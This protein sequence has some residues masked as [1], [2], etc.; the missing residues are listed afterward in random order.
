[1]KSIILDPGVIDLVLDDA[2]DFLSSKAWYAER[3]QHIIYCIT[4]LR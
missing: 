4:G 1:M 2:K 3:G